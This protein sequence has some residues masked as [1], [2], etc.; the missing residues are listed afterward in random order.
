MR[1]I[2]T[3]ILLSLLMECRA[4]LPSTTPD[5]SLQAIAQGPYT[6]CVYWRHEGR[7]A[8]LYA[9]GT[10][11]GEMAPESDKS[12]A[13]RSVTSLAPNTSYTFSL[14]ESSP[15]VTEKTW[16]ILPPQASFDV[17]V[18]GATASGVAAA[19]TAARMGLKVALVESS[20]RLGGMSSNGLGAADIRNPA[21]SSG[22]FEEFHQRVNAVYGPEVRP[23]FEPRIAGAVMKAMVYEQPNIT[24]F[25]R[26]D[27]IGAIRAA[28]RVCGAEVCDRAQGRRGRLLAKVTIDATDCADFAAACG[29][30]YRIGREPRTQ[31]E[32]HA[33]VIYFDD[34]AQAILPGSTGEGDAKVQSY[35]YLMTWKNYQD[36]PAPLVEKPAN[37]DPDDYRDS[38]QWN[39]TWNATSG[40][41]PN[42][43][44]EINQHPFGTDKPGVNYDYPCATQSRREI[45][46]IYR[47]RALGYLYFMQNERGHANLGL[48]D[49]EYV[50]SGNF[51]AGLYI[52]EA[53]RVMGEHI[54]NESEVTNARR[55]FR[56]DSIAITD[57][58]MDSHATEDIKARDNR[59]D[60][61]EGEMY[62]SSFTPW[63]Q[64]PYGV[65]VPR[66]V[67]GLLVTTAVSATHVAYGTLR[68]E[69]V[70][71][72]MGQAAGAAAYEAILRNISLRRINPAWIQD[73]ILSQH[74]YIYWNS[75][76]TPAT[77]HFKAIDFLAAR[78]VF[79][80]QAF[81]PDARLTEAEALDALSRMIE[82][83]GG[84][85][86]APPGRE[87]RNEGVT[88]G[89]FARWLV[90]AK[91][92]TDPTWRQ[93]P[94]R[95][96]RSYE[97]VAA[98]SPYFEAVE[99]LRAHRITPGLFE[100][101]KP[102]LFQP[103]AL[104][105]R[106]DAAE[107]IFLAH[108]PYAMR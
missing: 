65:I 28:D 39:I 12:F 18:I 98:D 68:L 1:P 101:H 66:R 55:Y 60:K 93:A 25:C 85:P 43:K 64:V 44:F 77:R 71:M 46:A 2:L 14:G 27:A 79:R 91:V 57:Y 83:E 33:G 92:T 13:C 58:P 41:L 69:P 67:E 19:V 75:D 11:I 95:R 34:R 104:I 29:A 31:A 16:S 3:L 96:W 70:R 89:L 97:D 59:L 103:D 20:N 10:R 9:D 50:D 100:G 90:Q 74:A 73:R 62:L 72:S 84:K 99:I 42:R 37:Y 26:T 106:A 107:A 5:G 24:L 22:F 47:D 32:P 63:S 94:T 81:R 38:P 21:R 30:E 82:L 7:S 102:G 53:R 52:R 105:S 6:I 108:R 54:L 35:S 76:V 51:P 40:R 80:E 78:G 23:R 61:G 15:A 86:A 48:A 88:R 36:K 87:L 17:L 49:D 4:D 45:E 8:P 56:A